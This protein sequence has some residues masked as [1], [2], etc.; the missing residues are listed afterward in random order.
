VRYL[1]PFV[2]L[3]LSVVTTT[4]NGARFMQ[5]FIEGMPPVVRE[6]DLWPWP[7]LMEHPSLFASGFA[8]STSLLLILL[9]HEFGH[10]FACVAH[11]VKV[12]LPWLLPAPTLSGTAGAVLQLQ[13][14]LPSRN[15]VMDVGI[16]GPIV[17]YIAS[18]IAV[19][20]GFAMSYHAPADAPNA[21]VRFDGEP[22][23]I[24]IVHAL[25][26]QWD[27]AIPDLK[28]ISPH[29]ILVAGWIGLFI[30]SLNLI[31]AGQLDG[32]HVLYALSPRAN[33]WT[34]KLLPLALFVAGAVCWVGWIL[35]GCFLLLPA[36]RHPKVQPDPPLTPGRRLLGVVAL[37][38]L[39]LTFTPSPF[40][41]SSLMHFLHPNPFQT[42]W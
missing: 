13:S 3:C 16:Y 18:T 20:V 29:P 11:R 15:A 39:L 25:I 17:G 19:A 9:T 36:M 10:Y 4:A 37:L 21:L 30:T 31:P 22:L 12:S 2:L 38:I 28:H 26:S 32:G 6:S 8:F 41:D 7:W 5:N 24:L 27:P 42:A 40:Y 14:R 33:R 35:W 23:T 34:T 1:T